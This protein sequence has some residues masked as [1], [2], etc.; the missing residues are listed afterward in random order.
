LGDVIELTPPRSTAGL[1]R[2]AHHRPAGRPPL[3]NLSLFRSLRTHL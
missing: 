3:A 1:G 2:R